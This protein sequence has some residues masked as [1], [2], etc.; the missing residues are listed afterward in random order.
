MEDL[1]KTIVTQVLKTQAIPPELQDIIQP[2]TIGPIKWK[3]IDEILT[4]LIN[5]ASYEMSKEIIKIID[6]EAKNSQHTIFAEKVI[7]KIRKMQ[8]KKQIIPDK[9]KKEEK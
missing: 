9:P 4:E 5:N 3:S 7:N 1:L 8:I 6:E 2:D